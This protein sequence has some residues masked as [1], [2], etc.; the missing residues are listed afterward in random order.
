ML[1]IRI[2]FLL[3][4]ICYIFYYVLIIGHLFNLWKLVNEKIEFYKMLIPFYYFFKL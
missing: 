2:L 4:V 3:F 1:Y